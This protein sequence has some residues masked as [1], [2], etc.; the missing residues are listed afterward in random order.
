MKRFRFLRKLSNSNE[1]PFIAVL[2]LAAAGFFSSNET[3]SSRT[4]ILVS[5]PDPDPLKDR[6]VRSAADQSQ[7][8]IFPSCF[9]RRIGLDSPGNVKKEGSG[10]DDDDGEKKHKCC[11]CFGRDTI[12]NAAA[13]VGPAVVNI[14]V[15]RSFHGLSAGRSIGSGTIK[16]ADGTILTCAHVVDFQGLRISSKGKIK[17]TTPLPTAKLGTSNKRLRPGDWV[18]AM[19]C[20]LSLQN[21]ITA[22][23][24][25]CVDRKS[26][27]LGLGGMRREYLQTDCA[28]NA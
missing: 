24:V 25:S 22:G 12:A 10:E 28:I 6:L 2:A 21:T 9:A 4:S 14:S 1:K 13:T 23:I 26:S 16:D 17:S 7:V 3:T 5:L 19:G 8:Y 15:S 27:D 20:P 18:V 11:N